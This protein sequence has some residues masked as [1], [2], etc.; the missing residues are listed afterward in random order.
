MKAQ[1]SVYCDKSSTR[2]HKSL[3]EER[4]TSDKAAT[5]AF[6]AQAGGAGVAGGMTA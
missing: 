1:A 2:E 3:Y 5:L 6:A 4:L